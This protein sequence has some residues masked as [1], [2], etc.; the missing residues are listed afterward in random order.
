LKKKDNSSILSVFYISAILLLFLLNPYSSYAQQVEGFTKVIDVNIPSGGFHLDGNVNANNPSQNIGD[1]FK[2]NNAGTGG[3]LLLDNGNP[4]D[5]NTTRF[6]LDATGNG[7]E[8][9]KG[10]EKLNE[11]PSNWIKI[12]KEVLDKG[13]LAHAM[14][15]ITTDL[16]G[17]QWMFLGADRYPK[18]DKKGDEVKGTSYI[19]FTL[20]QNELIETSNGFTTPSGGLVRKENDI[21]LSISY[22]N[23]GVRATFDLFLWNSNGGWVRQEVNENNSFARSH[24]REISVPSSA[25]GSSTL[26]PF[27]FVEGG[28]N[29]TAA[30]KNL[31]S[32]SSGCFEGVAIK[33]VLVKTKSSDSNTATLKDYI[34][35]I[36]VDL[37]LGTATIGYKPSEVCNNIDIAN[38]NIKGVTSGS[39]TADKPGLS[40]NKST[41]Q[42]DVKNSKPGVYTITYTF[43]TYGCEKTATT[44]FTVYDIPSK[45]E[46]IIEQPACNS[47]GGNVK[48]KNADSN[49]KYTISNDSSYSDTNTTGIFENLP[50]GTYAIVA[51]KSFDSNSGTVTCSS[52]E[53]DSF[54][55]EEV[56]NSPDAPAIVSTT[57]PTC[58]LATGTITVTK[59]SGIEYSIN[60]GDYQTN[61]TFAGLV[62]GNYTITAINTA[63]CVSPA[64]ETININKKPDTPQA[65]V[66]SVTE[67]PSCNLSSGTIKINDANNSFTYII[68][69]QDNFTDSNNT[70]IFDSLT[71]GNYT[72]TAENENGCE[73]DN[74]NTV[75]IQEFKDNEKPVFETVNNITQITDQGLCSAV[76]SFEIPTATDNCDGTTVTQTSEFGA[77]DTFPAGTTTVTYTATDA[78]GNTDTVSFDVIVTD[79]EDPT[80]NCPADITENVAFGET[81]AVV[82]Y[83]EVTFNDNCSATIEQTAGLASGETF[84][85]GTT[86]NTFVVTDASGNTATC[87]FDITIK[88]DGDTIPQ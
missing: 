40:I 1:W 17:D 88:E 46:L 68:S 33:S 79:N 20:F 6:V 85:V 19:D 5:Q 30:L 63:E 78:S 8:S 21:L 9:F 87:S 55:I 61:G 54:S 38:V 69:G 44:Q 36:K 48:I 23:G 70:G 34:S 72:V 43:D 29:L 42:I 45:P 32:G 4:V 83:N 41:G 47:G 77:G 27:L 58:D 53:S 59:V 64:S 28:I 75:S 22:T 7:D 73:S 2:G 86:T 51:S 52:T 66:I 76:V 62:P 18:S 39:F 14:Y 57:Q 56:P 80:I 65:P 84:P 37:S 74:S 25:Y 82:T 49:S 67:Q 60:G 35:P 26:D 3:F 12:N 16:N 71:P 11:D 24:A 31:G 50:A 10:G 13:D 15:H 81:G